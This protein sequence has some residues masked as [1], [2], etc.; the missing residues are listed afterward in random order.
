MNTSFR[1][2]VPFCVRKKSPVTGLKKF[3]EIFPFSYKNKHHSLYRPI[4][5]II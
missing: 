1:T 5:H 2:Y 3:V 4:Y